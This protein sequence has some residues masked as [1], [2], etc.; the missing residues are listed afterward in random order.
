[1][2]FFDDY[3]NADP[4]AKTMRVNGIT[5]FISDVFLCITFNK[6]IV[7]ATLISDASLKLFNSKLGLSVCRSGL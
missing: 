5:T 6:K 4:R 1:M 3:P 7:T 2:G